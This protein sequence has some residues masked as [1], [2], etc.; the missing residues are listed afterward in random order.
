MWC[1][2]VEGG[3][4]ADK[5]GFEC[6]L[7]VEDLPPGLPARVRGLNLCSAGINAVRCKQR[8]C[9]GVSS[10]ALAQHDLKMIAKDPRAWRADA[11][12][13]V[14]VNGKRSSAARLEAT[15]ILDERDD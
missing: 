15:Q 5:T 3:P 7:C 12:A 10:E 8:I 13:L 9:A 2:C 14:K 1:S 6:H 11:M 4:P